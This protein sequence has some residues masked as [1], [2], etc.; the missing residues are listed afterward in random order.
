V[1]SISAGTGS[2]GISASGNDTIT[3]GTGNDTLTATGS[4]TITGGS[5]NLY[6]SARSG[7]DST[8]YAGSGSETLIGGSGKTFFYGSTTGGS[9]YMVGGSGLNTFV[10]GNGSDTMVASSGSHQNS[11]FEFA[12]SVSGGV[13]TIDGFVLSASS[14]QADIVELKGYT[15][16]DIKSIM[17]MH[18]NTIIK[19][20]D[21]T[22]ITITG[23]TNFNAGDIKFTS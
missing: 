6:Y 21:H 16:S 14:K 15:A 1:Q 5:G 22:Q 13:H 7:V 20:D 3:L 18:G 9:D 4:A 10:G 17:Q 2:N 19:L 8:V 12:S 23:V 11:V